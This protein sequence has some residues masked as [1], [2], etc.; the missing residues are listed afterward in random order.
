MFNG[1]ISLISSNT[2]DVLEPL[3]VRVVNYKS[4]TERSWPT[5]EERSSQQLAGLKC[6]GG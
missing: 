3:Q 5:L 2:F 1:A 4:I 6:R